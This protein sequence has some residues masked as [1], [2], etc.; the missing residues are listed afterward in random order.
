MNRYVAIFTIVLS[1]FSSPTFARTLDSLPDELS[2][3]SSMMFE[4]QLMDLSEGLSPLL[5]PQD[6]AV[7]NPQAVLSRFDF[8]GLC[9]DCNHDS[10][11]PGFGANATAELMLINYGLGDE[12]S[13]LNFVSFRYDGSDL[14]HSFTIDKNNVESSSL[15]G[16]MNS[17]SGFADLRVKSN[18]DF[19]TSTASNGAWSLGSASPAS[20]VPDDDN[21]T[22]G[23]FTNAVPEPS[24]IALLGLG[25]F[26]FA[27][28]RRKT[29]KQLAMM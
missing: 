8:S 3:F 26:G 10:F 12:I 4:F 18:T 11:K 20:M 5:S 13:S 24:S 29:I 28:S 22:V 19:F 14:H 15:L 1:L 25:F 6:L 16:A 27:V 23:T 9:T 7:V 17:L 2:L 21:G